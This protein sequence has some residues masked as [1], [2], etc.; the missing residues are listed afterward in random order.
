M[1]WL[2]LAGQL[3][4]WQSGLAGAARSAGERVV[5]LRRHLGSRRSQ[6]R[7]AYLS[8]SRFSELAS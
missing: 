5:P 7:T 3:L 2:S 8:S 4:A 1:C 6:E